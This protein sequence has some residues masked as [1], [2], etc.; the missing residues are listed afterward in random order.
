MISAVRHPR[1]RDAVTGRDELVRDPSPGNGHTHR[2][3]W[4]GRT[5]HF[6]EDL[7]GAGHGHDPAE[8]VD[9]ALEANSTGR[10]ALWISLGLLGLTALAQ[11]VVVA[12]TGSVA[13]LGD[14][15]H[16]IVDALTSVPLLV[17]FFWARRA[18]TRRFTYGFGRGEDLA[19]LFILVMI[20][21][22]AV[23]VAWEAVRRL[24]EPQ[25]IQHLWAVALAGVI[26]FVGN[27]LVARYRIRV[28]HRIGS[29]ALVADGLHARTDGFTSL[30]VVLSAGGVA[31]GWGW[32]D[33]VVALLITVA[34]VGVLR[35]AGGQVWGRL[36]DS[37]DP[38]LVTRA[39]EAA[40][41]TP[42]VTEVQ[43]VRLRWTGHQLLADVWI[44]A[45]PG[46]ALEVAHGLAH[47]VEAR[48]CSVLP[49][50]QEATVHVSP[51]GAH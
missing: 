34:I 10:R 14:T 26:G 38:A 13:L 27:E 21:L 24:L 1:S 39:E 40:A 18:A 37:V 43:R 45:E 6:L 41:A 30:A 46:C 4:R 20:A 17:A 25:A 9:D 44:G 35:S 32:A 15:M 3:G 33:P 12:F 8:Q 2:G 19:G 7:V 16:N 36:M 47:D 42:S 31:A 49:R 23:L 28:G 11:A 22:S 29:A 5:G 50:L 48:L 51:T